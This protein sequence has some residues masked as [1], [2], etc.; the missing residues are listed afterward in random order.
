MP[1]L[2]L[3]ALGLL[4]ALQ[5][6]PAESIVTTRHHVTLDGRRLDYTARAGR[7]PIRYNETGEVHAW[8]FFVAYTKDT[9]EP[10]RPLT[11][12]WNGGPGS[13]AALIQLRGIGP[14]RFTASGALTDNEGTWLDR[15]DLVFVDPVGTGYSRVTRAE[16]GAE[17]YST[18]GDAESIAEFIRV[19]RTRYGRWESP[20]FL[21]GESFGVVRAAG[22]AEVLARR[23]IPLEGVVLIGLMAPL[24]PVPDHVANALHVPTWTAAA[25]YHRRLAPGLQRD[26]A[27]AFAQSTAWATDTLAP[28]LAR[29]DS[30]PPEERARLVG[31]LAGY[32]GVPIAALD[33]A[34]L[35]LSYH[36]FARLLLRDRGD[37]LG[38]YDARLTAPVEKGSGP[39]D[40]NADPSLMNYFPADGVVRYLRDELGYRN[41]LFYTGPFGGAWPPAEAVRGDWMSVRW[42]WTREEAASM[43]RPGQADLTLPRAMATNPRLR[44]F[45]TCGYY[46]L[47]CDVAV[48]DW[49]AR[50]LPAELRSRVTV[51]PYTGGHAVYMDDVARL[52]L[53]RDVTEFMTSRGRMR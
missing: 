20:L 42:K 21:A 45:V 9:A 47:V 6:A 52:Q 50:Q 43:S 48:N 26:S 37:R 44:V 22:V 53:K 4:A 11:F 40:P 19:F 1:P 28:A 24:A 3:P 33:S 8:V 15:T 32:I 39:Y 36:R 2:T 25:W 35:D 51:R 13:N 30:L 41:D 18:K 23:A 38:H 49:I 34:P 31:Q 12:A 29:R 16:Y 27:R 14:R 46:D 17:F 7:L 10:G 5:G